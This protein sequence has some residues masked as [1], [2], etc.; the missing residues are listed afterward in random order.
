MTDE[1]LDPIMQAI[2]DLIVR[3]GEVPRAV[4]EHYVRDHMPTLYEEHIAPGVIAVEDAVTRAHASRRDRSPFP[5]LVARGFRKWLGRDAPRTDDELLAAARVI[6]AILEQT[7]PNEHPG[8]PMNAD[9]GVMI[10]H[11]FAKPA[12][13]HI[14]SL[15]NAAVVISA[16]PPQRTI[17]KE[18]ELA[19]LEHPAW[20]DAD[21]QE[22]LAVARGLVESSERNPE[23]ERGIIELLADLFGKPGVFLSDRKDEVVRDLGWSNV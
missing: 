13:D 19:Q 12:V 20:S 9:L 17:R 22:A 1:Q 7:P 3:T 10:Q 14:L 23:Y 21:Y 15:E 5:V 11:G 4:V 18:E 8:G 6:V 2:A 16:L